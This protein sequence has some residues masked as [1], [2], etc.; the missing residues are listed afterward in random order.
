[1]DLSVTR[2]ECVEQDLQDPLAAV[3]ERFHMPDNTIYLDGNSLGPLPLAAKETV[4]RVVSEQWGADLIRS[5]NEHDWIGLP[6][7]TGDKIAALIGSASGQVVATDSTSI[8]LF[9]LL[10]AALDL[11]G[12]RRVILSTRENFPTDL[13]MAEGLSQLLGSARCELRVVPGERVE[14]SIT[15]EVAVVMLTHVDFRSGRLFDMAAITRRAHEAG[16]LML[17]DLAHSAGALPV[18]LD[19]CGADLAV[20]CGYK[21]LNGGPGAPA[22]LYVAERHHGRLRQP[23]AGWMGHARPFEFDTGY[24]P[25]PGIEHFL[26]GTPPVL[27]MAALDAA[28]DQWA[29]IDLQQVRTKSVALGDLFI[30]L[31]ESSKELGQMALASPREASQRGSQVSF[32]HPEGY[33][34][35]QAL[36]HAGVIGDYREPDLLRFGFTPLYTR[37]VDVWDAVDTLR[38]IVADQSYLE[39][40][41][42]QRR[43]VT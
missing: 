23:L 35:M 30:R 6:R 5:W 26:C 28:L 43:K 20:G 27:A 38:R 18:H 8:N 19:E 14:D 34:L 22:F 36:I 25:A 24:R 4:R 37:F 15:D 9:K 10:S 17:W 42:S 33:A 2:A 41:F 29:D 3:R 32:A 13:Y 39:P 11:N 16:A 40:R 21:Y 12:D 31:V 7:R 1:M